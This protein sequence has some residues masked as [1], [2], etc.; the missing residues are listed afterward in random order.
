MK[1]RLPDVYRKLTLFSENDN[2]NISLNNSDFLTLDIKVA[3]CSC[4]NIYKLFINDK[5]IRSVNINA[6]LKNKNSIQVI[7]NIFD[8]EEQFVPEELFSDIFVIGNALGNK[9]LMQPFIDM[10]SK[11]VTFSNVL[12]NISLKASIGAPINYEISFVAKYFDILYEKYHLMEWCLYNDPDIIEQI[13]RSNGFTIPSEDKFINILIEL[14]SNS[15]KYDHLLSYVYLEYASDEASTKFCTFIAEHDVEHSTLIEIWKNASKKLSMKV[16]EEK[17]D[18]N[19]NPRRKYSQNSPESN[20]TVLLDPK[21]IKQS[22]P[23]DTTMPLSNVFSLPFTKR[24]AHEMPTLSISSTQQQQQQQQSREAQ[25]QQAIAQNQQQFP[26]RR[27][28]NIISNRF[29]S[30]SSDSSDDETLDLIR[31]RTQFTPPPSKPE[32]TS[33][34]RNNNENDNLLT[35][36][37]EADIPHSEE[38]NFRHEYFNNNNNNNFNNYNNYTNYTPRNNHSSDSEDDSFIL[39]NQY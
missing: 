7:C 36:S 8:F 32:Q 4:E 21:K 2:F 38:H 37:I 5:S 23:V 14:C 28:R 24:F 1:I 12:Q 27:E 39:D 25:Q 16:N 13:I 19:N 15:H 26:Q 33:P 31:K 10:L 9:E 18:K 17:N 20:Q 11:S 35:Q 30:D 29:F 3:V 22:D 6:H 34:I